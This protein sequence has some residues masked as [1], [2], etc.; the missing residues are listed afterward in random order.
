MNNDLKDILDNRELKE[1]PFKV[2]EYYFD[3]LTDRI[4][5]NIPEETKKKKTT[6]IFSLRPMKWA[7]S[8]ACIIAISAS[9][10]LYVSR[11]SSSSVAINAAD[12]MTMPSPNN[13]YDIIIE[14]ADYTMLDNQE[15]YM[16]L[17]DE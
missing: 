11:N 6:R 14:A 4:M 1:F 16:L 5:A 17:A 12:T 2:P 8:I 10:I 3:T 7:A 15:I 9:S 13:S